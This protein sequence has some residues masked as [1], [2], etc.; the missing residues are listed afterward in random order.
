[1]T[2][3]IIL[4]EWRKRE[5]AMSIVVVFVLKTPVGQELT[6]VSGGT[7]PSSVNGI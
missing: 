1:V 2:L 6:I 3:V 5:I 7:E 4:G